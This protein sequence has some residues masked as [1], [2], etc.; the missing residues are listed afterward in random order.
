[1]TLEMDVDEGRPPEPKDELQ[2]FSPELLRFYYSR[3]FP[4]DLMYRWLSYANM[5]AKV[6]EADGNAV[7]SEEKSD[8]F[9][10]REFSFTIEDD[11][12]IRYLCFADCAE[13]E[14]QVQRKQP[15]KI[16]IGAVFS[17]PPK[18]HLT[19]KQEAFVPMERE[20]VF[21]IDLTDYDNVRTCCSGA[22][23][24][25]RCWSY[26]VMAVEVMDRGL[27]QDFGFHHILWVYSG[28]RGVHCWVSDDVARALTNEGRAAVADYFTVVAGNDNQSSKVH[29]PLPIHPALQRAYEILEPLFIEHI[30]PEEGQGLLS[31]PEKREKLFASLP[32]EGMGDDLEASWEL[33]ASSEEEKWEELVQAVEKKSKAVK[34][35]GP[36]GKKVK[37]LQTAPEQWRY[38]VVFEH[39]YPRLDVNVSKSRNHLL[40]SPFAV[41]PKTGRVCVPIDPTRV[42]EFN[43]FAVPTLGELMRQIDRFDTEKGDE[44]KGVRAVDKT[45]MKA[46]V[47]CF[48]NTFLKGLSKGFRA[49]LRDKAE[50][51]AAAIADF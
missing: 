15:H 38:E 8:F 48:E 18:D 27:R 3:L 41:H 39:C 24:C 46:A 51:K 20:L 34:E 47:A 33:S 23:I 35:K 25:R 40:K 29:V 26:M 16:D 9:Q 7:P 36:K 50:R 6:P 17:L 32:F 12:Y 5:P 13:F 30:L 42:S 49:K 1:M 31:D 11:I 21:D 14:Q 10:R 37:G 2:A 45:S 4:Y 28:R 22:K 43:P 44:A 19:V